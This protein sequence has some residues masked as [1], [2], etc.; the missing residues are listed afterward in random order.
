MIKKIPPTFTQIDPNAQYPD[1]R[2]REYA[3][4]HLLDPHLP[5]PGET[6]T[7]P[8]QTIGQWKVDVQGNAEAW[9]HSFKIW[10]TEHL[11]RIGYDDSQYCR[12]ELEWSQKNYVHTQMMV[13]DRYFY[14]PVA[15]KYTI[16]KYLDDLIQR[17]GGIDSVLLWYVYPNIGIDDRSQTDLASDL[18]GGLDGLKQVVADFHRRG[19]KV[20]LP[21]MPW[22]NGT[23]DAGK[24]DAEALT[25]I[26]AYVKADGI[27]GDTYRGVPYA[28]R[29]ASDEIGHPVVLQPENPS[30]ADDSLMWNNQSW[31]TH[32]ETI[33]P[34]VSRLKWLESRH[35]INIENRWGRDRT[36][37]FHYMF[38]NGIGYVAW[39]NVW[40]IWNQ[41]T[42]RAGE[43]LRRISS[44]YRQFPTLL[45]S[46]EWE[47]Y[48]STVQQGV[49]ASKFP[50][51]D[52]TLWTIVNRNEYDMTG[53]QLIVDYREGQRYYDL[54]N[55]TE[56]QPRLVGSKGYISLEIETK[57]F[58]SV[59]AVEGGVEVAGLQEFLEKMQ[60]M[61][62]LPLQSI[63]NAWKSIPQQII[64]I[65]STKPVNETPHGMLHIPGDYFDFKVGGLEIEGFTDEG[66]DFQYPWENSARRG[67]FNHMKI[68][69]FYIDRYPVTNEQY[70][71]FMQATNYSP[72]DEHNFLRDWVD[73]KPQEGW[74]HKPVTWISIED[75]RVYALW[76]G[77]RLPH[78]WEWQYAAQGTDG[79]LFPWGNKWD[80]SI[81][82]EQNSGRTILPPADVDAH[83]RGASPFGVMDLV[84]NVWQWTDEFVDEHTRA[85][86]LRGG[87]SYLP[88]TSHWYFPQ[89][90]RLD[91]HG[92]Y[93]LMAPCKD[94]SGMIGF[95]C[96]VDAKNAV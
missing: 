93:L 71:E 34:A 3:T 38:F 20:F 27:N 73:G 39:E 5:T 23:R 77:K 35:L 12:K 9:R 75:S 14:D 62:E 60:K 51:D 63:S 55:G 50:D 74:G 87:S 40:G 13:E 72:D 57:G 28:F 90:Y 8:F 32:S 36:N 24:S 4:W 47:P 56:L 78:E 33:I 92:K 21:T 26:A 69:G 44:I 83:P 58:A 67:H 61:T 10:R 7:W 49:F 6:P 86:A 30:A 84:G 43:A 94:R 68:D 29:K 65:E 85:A 79:R 22:D 89:A 96:V 15:G 48:A 66:I 11:I 81:V 37:D 76:A 80:F 16:D 95:R 19:V 2:P 17:Y 70:Y 45:V 82:P 31:G 52:S 18:P 64:P 46:S 53:D 25:E 54:W 88:R 42:P 1:P 91:Q 59:L 41:F